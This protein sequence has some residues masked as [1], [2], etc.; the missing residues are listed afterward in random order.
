VGN[1]SAGQHV[2]AACGVP[3]LSIFAGFS[4]ARMAARW[5]PA[6]QVI[7]VEDANPARVLEQV[8]LILPEML[9]TLRH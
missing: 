3:L 2:A 8:R 6:G 4:C 5:R 1:D 9:E 7:R